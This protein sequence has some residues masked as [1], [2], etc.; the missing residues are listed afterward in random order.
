MNKHWLVGGSLTNSKP[1][2]NSENIPLLLFNQCDYSAVSCQTVFHINQCSVGKYDSAWWNTALIMSWHF[3][4]VC[5]H[6]CKQPLSAN[7]LWMQYFLDINKCHPNGELLL[8]FALKS[9]HAWQ[10]LD[11]VQT[12]SASKLRLKWCP[13]YRQKLKMKS[14]TEICKIISC[15]LFAQISERACST[16]INSKE[17]TVWIDT[18]IENQ[19]LQWLMKGEVR[20]WSDKGQN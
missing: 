3:C 8:L 14:F 17:K 20:V 19:Y 15:V 10:V 5:F 2:L 4:C 16:I 18:K 9:H 1:S 12:L 6:P 7:D 13:E 11:R